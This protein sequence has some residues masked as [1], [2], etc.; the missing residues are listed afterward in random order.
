MK[1]RGVRM[2][3]ISHPTV[4]IEVQDENPG[5]CAHACWY[6]RP[7]FPPCALYE[8]RRGRG[9]LGWVRLPLCIKEF[10]TGPGTAREG[11]PTP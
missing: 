7:H 11:S 5:F 2:K 6:N 3:F 10:G 1:I 8:Q 4:E 9:G